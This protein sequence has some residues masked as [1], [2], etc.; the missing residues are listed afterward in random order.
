M[1]NFFKTK[2]PDI[3]AICPHC[4]KSLDKFPARKQ[5]CPHCGNVFVV[6]THYITHNKILLTETDAVRFDAEKDKYYL[7]KSLIDGLKKNIDVDK[8]EVD[9]LVKITQVDLT[10]KF[11][12]PASLGDVAWGVANRMSVDAMRKGNMGLLRMI[13]FQM[14]LY[15][16]HC[17]KD[18]RQLLESGFEIELRDYKKMGISKVSVMAKSCCEECKI[19]DGR[20]LGIDDAMRD[21][22]L[23]YRLCTSRLNKEAPTGWCTCCYIP[24]VDGLGK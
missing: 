16:H 20:I 15:L 18:G 1:F 12:R 23:P 2:T 13:Q 19:Q 7:D 17:G 10:K 3:T 22:I 4:S 9:K 5:K 6:R 11:G 14:A 24:V 21:K 8:N